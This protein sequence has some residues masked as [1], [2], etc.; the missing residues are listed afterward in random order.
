MPSSA[1]WNKAV[2]DAKRVLGNSAKIP[3]KRVDDVLKDAVIAH[4]A[5]D[6]LDVLRE[7]MKKKI[8]EVQTADSRVD[9]GLGLAADE[10][11]DED[12]GLDSKKP[13]D[14]KKIDQ[15]HQIF[16]NFFKIA[17]KNFEDDAKNLRE[18]NKHLIDIASYKR[19]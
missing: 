17:Q 12:F 10:M 7:Q 14:K 15:A 2:A 11:D 8:L 18:L 19:S 4:K 16:A 13:D 1:M 6:G 3:T 5:F 9:N